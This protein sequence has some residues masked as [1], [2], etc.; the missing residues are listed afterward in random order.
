MG[1]FWFL[2]EILAAAVYMHVHVKYMC[3]NT[4]NW[5]LWWR[6]DRRVLSVCLSVGLSVC[7]SVVVILSVHGVAFC[8]DIIAR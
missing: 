3:A 5:S 2:A 1:N 7:L 8:A 6:I 4:E